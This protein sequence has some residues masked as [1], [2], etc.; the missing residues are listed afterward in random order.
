MKKTNKLILGFFAILL[1]FSCNDGID[2]IS[3]VDP[4]PDTGAPVITILRPADGLEIQV[5]EPVTSTIIQFRVEDDIEIGHISVMLDGAEIA[6]FNSFVDY[7][8]ANE[9]F[10]Y[11]NITTGDHVL[12][13]T[14]TDLVGNV[15]TATSNFTKAPPYTPIFAGEMFYMPFD[16]DFTELISVTAA[17]EIGNPGF[18]GNGAAYLGNGYVAGTNNYLSYPLEGLALGDNLS[19]TFWYKVNPSPDRSGI[20]VIGNDVPENRQQGIR[21]FREGNGNEQRIKLNVG[22]G[23]GESW[24]DGGVIN[25]TAGEWVHVAF[26]ISPTQTKIYLNGIEQLTGNMSAPVDWTGCEQLT[27]GAGGPTFSYWNH[28]SDS[29]IM[30]EL[31]LFNT[32]LTQSEIMNM[33]AYGSQTFHMSFNNSYAEAFSSTEATT[34]GNPGF[35]SDA[36]V[37][38]ASY[39]GASNAYLSFPINGLFGEDEFTAAFWYKVNAT[40]DRAG[41]LVVG[42]P[43]IAENRNQG[44]RLFREG[45]ATEQR[46][47]LN[48]GTGTGESWNDGGVINVTAGEWVHITVTVSPTQS[49]IYFNGVPTLV[50]N[51]TSSI[52]WTGCSELTIGSGGPTFSYWNH[53]SD[54]SLIDELK[55]FNRALTQDEVL[56]LQ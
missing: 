49:N 22:T 39:Q 55:I 38:S 33:I 54:L 40:P 16:G 37:G 26:T 48:I 2:P 28:L 11:N 36:Q 53:L 43:D 50:S 42:T 19:G 29:S 21:L 18:S 23:S 9:E 4:G 6:T 3:E 47:K 5:P 44:F 8:I 34:T 15:S 46:I 20:L 30:D 35:S 12:T 31:R 32:T 17:E 52:D 45:N 14:A 1:M 56:S 41:I 24:N 13:V 10:V 7:R 27:I 25:V 51:F